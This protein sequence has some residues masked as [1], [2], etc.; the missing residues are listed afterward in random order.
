MERE[1]LT[2]FTG[3]QD[4]DEFVEKVSLYMSLKGYEGDK[5]AQFLASKLSH[6]AF[7]VYR[8]MS[9]DDKK[10]FDKL[11]AELR[12][13]YKRGSRDREAALEHISK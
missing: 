10:D 3:D 6:G 8:R 5:K 4:V 2:V 12:Q 11:V 1:N 7:Q 9:T 13:E